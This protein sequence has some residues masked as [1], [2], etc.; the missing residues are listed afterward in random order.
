MDSNPDQRQHVFYDEGYNDENHHEE[1]AEQGL[2]T[3]RPS[4]SSLSLNDLSFLS[5]SLGTLNT[6]KPSTAVHVD[7][8]KLS[9]LECEEL[10]YQLLAS[11]P[12]SR[13]ATIQ[14]KLAPLLQ[15]DVVGSLPAE[16]SLQIFSYLPFPSLLISALVCRRWN[17]LA[18]DQTLW[19]KLCDERGWKW[20]HRHPALLEEE[21]PG[22]YDRKGK[23]RAQGAGAGGGGGAAVG[24]A[25][26]WGHSDDDEGMGDSDEEQEQ[27]QG[28]S[29]KKRKG[30]KNTS[31]QNS[32][33]RNCS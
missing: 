18:N 19:K 7:V 20:K 33:L 17:I 6:L 1:R 10:A 4:S 31:F 23:A 30:K 32:K 3:P 9:G 14:R 12:R 16:V 29:K 27:E 28:E 24:G 8:D 11:L 15:F 25:N 5:G 22:E 2:S 26:G 13:L 21:E